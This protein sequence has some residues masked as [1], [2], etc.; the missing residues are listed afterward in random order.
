MAL[1]ET[2]RLAVELGFVD[3]FTPGLRKAN[4]QL[5]TFQGSVGKIG[6]GLGQMSAGITR[7]GLRTGGALALGLTAVAKATIDWQDAFQGVV[8]TVDEADLKRAGLTFEDISA[9]LREMAR[10]MPVTHEE[11]AG[12]AANAGALGIAGKDILAFTKQV[13]IIG[14]TTN[15]SVEDAATALGQLQNVIGLTADEFDNFTAALV[16]LGN[17]GASTEAQILEIARRAGGSAKLIGIAKEQTLGWAA[18]AANLGLNEELAGTALQNVFIKLLPKFTQGSKVLTKVTGKTAKQL[19]KDFEKNAGGA[20]ENL[21]KQLGKMPKDARLEAVQGLFGKSSGITRLVLGLAESYDKNLNPSLRNSVDAWKKATAAQVEYVNRSQTAK[22]A[23]TRLRNGIND[24]AISIGEGFAPAVG[25]AAD[26]LSK[27]LA[28]PANVAQL[29]SIGKDIGDAIDRI[30]WGQVIQQGKELVGVLKGALGFAKQLFDAFNALPGPLKEAAAGF[31]AIDK[32][33][34]GLF[35]AGVGSLVS[36]IASAITKGL[37]SG[38]AVAGIGKFFVQP[39]FVT[40]PGFGVPGAGG[41]PVAGG[42]GGGGIVNTALKL[43]AIPTIAA[44]ADELH[45]A[46]KAPPTIPASQLEWPF[47]PKNTPNILPNLELAGFKLSG[48]NG[49]LG[50]QPA[51]GGG[52]GNVHLAPEI[53]RLQEKT[54]QLADEQHRQGERASLNAKQQKAAIDASK[55]RL[56]AA[57]AETKR[58]TTRGL[59]ANKAAV[60]ADKS[61]VVAAT[62]AQTGAIVGAIFAA[63]PIVNVTSIQRTTTITNR[64]SNTPSSRGGTFNSDSNIPP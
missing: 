48:K 21:I 40:N 52:G 61:A 60:N 32:L 64:Y 34:S 14:S 43:L 56:A 2:A 54:R 41:P 47:G 1:A 59:N 22:S 50:G 44:L 15:V 24:A 57:Q 31:I 51:G 30:D 20:I 42:G 27:F 25:R 49:I 37:A 19:K 36:G 28:D 5:N 45:E 17:K 39:V 11:L 12:I 33:S 29:K 18:A 35:S 23:L 38:L 26:K 6:T 13:A 7:A 16:D 10:T 53:K 55:Q 46:I 8:K 63:R 4:R 62:I 9:G 3:K 58:E